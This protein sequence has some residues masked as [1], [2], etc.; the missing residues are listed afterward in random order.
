M[1]DS[2]DWQKNAAIVYRLYCTERLWEY[3][4]GFAALYTSVNALYVRKGYFTS[5]MKARLFPVWAYATGFNLAVTF[6]LLKPL[7]KDEIQVQLKKR[8]IMGKWLYSL[9]HLDPIEQQAA[10]QA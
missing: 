6:I 9:F 10:T 5:T 4:Y 2:Y 7:H 1:C 3:T 8:M